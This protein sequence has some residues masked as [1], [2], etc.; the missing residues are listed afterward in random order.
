[1][2]RRLALLIA[3]CAAAVSYLALLPS[4]PALGAAGPG[5]G[6]PGSGAVA[7]SFLHPS[8]LGHPR[9]RA[10]QPRPPASAPAGLLAACEQRLEGSRRQA[11]SHAPTLAIV[12]ASFTAGVGPGRPGR[13]WAVL[14]ARQLHWN[15]VV[16]GDPGAGYVRA[17]AGRRGP[18]AAELARV[19]LRA[20]APALV[21]VQAGHDDIGVPPSVER[22]RVTAVIDTIRAEV[23]GARIALLTVFP[24]R[25]RPGAGDQTDRAIVTAGQAA[26]H[27]VIIMD[28]LTGHWV[29]GR[30]PDG[31]H[32]TAAGDAWIAREVAGILQAHGV[33]PAAAR[34]GTAGSIVCDSGIPAPRPAPSAR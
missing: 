33:R 14:L 29:F 34:A 26:D 17:G 19:G 16:D 11:G 21:I 7:S 28:P 31:L 8:R 30:S 10:E 9:G 20:L 15:A 5:W 1:V 23:P 6:T 18:V 27:Q 32:P 3:A 2:I 24:G 12:G 25:R 13:S 22:Q 4:G